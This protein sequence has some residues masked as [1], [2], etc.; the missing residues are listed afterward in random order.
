MIEFGVGIFD[1]D[2]VLRGTG[3]VSQGFSEGGNDAPD[4]SFLFQRG[5][6]RAPRV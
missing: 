1:C 5:F 6:R 3:D 2:I 4:Q